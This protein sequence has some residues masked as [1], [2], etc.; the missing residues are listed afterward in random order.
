MQVQATLVYNSRTRETSQSKRYDYVDV[1]CSV[2]DI[3]DLQ[4]C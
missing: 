3:D 1:V 2:G 4:L